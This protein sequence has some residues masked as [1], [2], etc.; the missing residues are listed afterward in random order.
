MDFI[1]YVMGV[2]DVNGYIMLWIDD[3]IVIYNGDIIFCGEF[4]IKFIDEINV[5]DYFYIMLLFSSDGFEVSV[6]I[7][8]YVIG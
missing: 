2:E 6:K 1:I 8:W 3:F 4:F 7:M 5:S